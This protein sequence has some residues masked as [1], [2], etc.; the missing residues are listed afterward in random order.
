[1]KRLICLVAVTTLASGLLGTSPLGG[2]AAVAAQ[3]QAAERNLL[4][5]SLGHTGASRTELT[6]R[7]PGVE[8][9]C[10][11]AVQPYQPWACVPPR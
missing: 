1:M 11:Y 7:F 6:V 5:W 8:N 2:A 9:G 3:S 10:V 4:A